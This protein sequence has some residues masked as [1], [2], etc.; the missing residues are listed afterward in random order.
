MPEQIKYGVEN[1]GH[2]LA[3]VIVCAP[4]DEYFITEAQ[5]LKRHNFNHPPDRAKAV[6]QH[7]KLVAEMEKCGVEVIIV[8]EV[9]DHPNSVFVQDMAIMTKNG[10]VKLRMGIESREGEENSMAAYLNDLN[11]DC[12]GEIRK[13]GKVEGGDVIMAGDVAFI[14][15]SSRTNEEGARQLAAILQKQGVEA[16]IAPVPKWSLHIGGAMSVIGPNTILCAEGAFTPVVERDLFKGFDVIKSS[17]SEGEGGFASG[18]V[19]TIGEYN[20]KTVLISNDKNKSLN[21]QL[22]DLGYLVIAL[23]MSEFIAGHGGLSCLIMPFL[24]ILAGEKNEDE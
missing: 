16:R 7:Q 23:D 10:Y 6:S 2:K 22:E 18:N 1:E 5:D 3:T 11:V 8:S 20:G 19:I 17:K 12:V 9:V 21:A 4:K 24:R 13:P 15:I 14:G